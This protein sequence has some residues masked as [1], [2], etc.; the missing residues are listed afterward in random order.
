MKITAVILG[1]VF[2]CSVLAYDWEGLDYEDNSL[3][4]VKGEERAQLPGMCWGCKWIVNKVK[5]SIS[6]GTTQDEI[7][8]KLRAACDQI[9]FLRSACKG[10]I[11]RYIT[12][13]IEEVSTTDDVRTI[14]VNVKACKPKELIYM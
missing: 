8:G 6:N 14:C 3:E 1:S 10:F 9:G 12:V 2:I 4:V 11:K 5:K 7:Q 13:L